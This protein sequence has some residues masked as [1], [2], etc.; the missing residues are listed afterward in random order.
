MPYTSG[1]VLMYHEV[2]P[3]KMALPAWTVV[4]E[5]EFRWQMS[6]LLKHFDV[7]YMDQAIERVSNQR[8]GKKPFA[9]VTFDDGYR[10]NFHTV[11]PIMKSMGIPFVVYAATQAIV[12][13]KLYWYD[14]V[15][16]LLGAR[17]GIEIEIAQQGG[18]VR[19]FRLSASSASDYIRWQQVE[20]ILD[21][22]KRM[23]PE[24]RQKNIDRF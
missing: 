5:S 21:T 9:V 24:D 4:R 7:V 6:Y 12:D 13:Q 10:G 1:I 19:A 20:R 2:L 3:D 18:C 16:N 15:I 8:K 14:H 22:L 17:D 23:P 11:L